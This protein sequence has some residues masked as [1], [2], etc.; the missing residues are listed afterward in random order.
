MI[1]DKVVK[2]LNEQ[3]VLEAEA[4]QDYLAMAVWAEKAAFRG[5]AKFMYAQAEEERGHMFKIVRFMLEAGEAP[6]VP[7][8]KEPKAD[9]KDIEEVFKDAMKHEKK[10]TAAIHGIMTA[11]RSTNDYP[12]TSFIKW[13]I[14]EQVEEEAN[15]QLALDIIR[16]AG[17]VS[18]YL[19]DK[20]IGAMRGD[21]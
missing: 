16:L 20:D 18:M 19:A 4:S 2:L 14:D 21:K 13:F 1:S 8:V 5:T 9:F 7:A 12:V 6:I 17:K 15:V 11:A 10:V 3:I